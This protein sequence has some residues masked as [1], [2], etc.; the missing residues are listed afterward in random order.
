MPKL[1][2]KILKY[3]A[4]LCGHLEITWPLVVF[5]ARIVEEVDPGHGRGNGNL[6]TLFALTPERF[7]GDLKALAGTGEFRVLQVPFAWQARLVNLFYPLA[8]S[9]KLL[10]Q[11]QAQE[12]TARMQ[13]R[14]RR[15]LRAF[16]P[17]LY[18]RLGVDCVVGATI[19][20][21]HDRDWGAVSEDIGAPYVVLQRENLFTNKGHFRRFSKLAGDLGKFEG[22][23]VIVHNEVARDALTRSG[24]V[25]PEK[26]ST[27][28]CLRMDAFVRAVKSHK[29]SPDPNR[30]KRVLFVSFAPGSG[31]SG[32]CSLWPKDRS[33]GLVKLFEH[34]HQAFGELVR[35]HPEIDFVI[36]P[37]FGAHWITEI[38]RVLRAHGIAPEAHGNLSMLPDADVQA[39]V[40]D[41]DVVCGY[42]SGVLLEAA[43]AAKPIIIPYYDEA[44]RSEFSD[45]IQFKDHFRL[46]DIAH[47]P[48]E[49]KSL[50]LERLRDP[51]IGEACLREREALFEYYV[52]SLTADAVEKYTDLLKR[53]IN[54]KKSPPVSPIA[55]SPM[56][57]A[58]AE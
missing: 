29:N 38:E 58:P 55:N 3:P 10:L 15:F 40:L 18:R 53:I 42:G 43:I 37:K 46:F 48:A 34:T 12:K 39:L 32:L 5:Y 47:S 25:V 9:R 22:S 30:R 2:R 21:V 14:Y 31:L 35:D 26:I 56:R 1:V 17:A 16:L 4:L 44:L 23:H 24:F 49:F 27:L 45:Y 20:Y 50:V 33:F 11:P 7:R 6:P 13:K 57:P 8:M 28:G 36:K 52:S 19:H 41:S 54:E 51:A